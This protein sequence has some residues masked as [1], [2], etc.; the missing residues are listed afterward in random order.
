MT[1][2]VNYLV[3]GLDKIITKVILFISVIMPQVFVVLNSHM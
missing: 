3:A 2:S 1:Y